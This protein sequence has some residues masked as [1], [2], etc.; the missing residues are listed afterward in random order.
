LNGL[1]EPE[2]GD[3]MGRVAVMS[4]AGTNGDPLGNTADAPDVL[5]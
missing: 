1:R 2:Y 3:G 4:D 5:G